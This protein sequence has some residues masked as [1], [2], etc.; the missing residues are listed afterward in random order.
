MGIIWI[1]RY[2]EFEL[3]CAKIWHTPLS[4]LDIDI[5]LHPDSCQLSTTQPFVINVNF[6]FGYL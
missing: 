1:L 2:S 5:A 3:S 6:S 4:S